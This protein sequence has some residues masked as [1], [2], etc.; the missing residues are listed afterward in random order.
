MMSQV[1]VKEHVHFVTHT[2]FKSYMANEEENSEM[3]VWFLW[4]L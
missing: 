3:W 1:G 2:N 4:S